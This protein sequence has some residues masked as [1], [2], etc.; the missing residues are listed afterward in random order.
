MVLYSV[1]QSESGRVESPGV[2][3][4]DRSESVH[5]LSEMS[6]TPGA[7]PQSAKMTS[8]KVKMSSHQ[9]SLHLEF[10]ATEQ[11]EYTS[12]CTLPAEDEEKGEQMKEK[13][14]ACISTQ[15]VVLKQRDPLSPDQS[16]PQKRKHYRPEK[17]IEPSVRQAPSASSSSG[18]DMPVLE[19]GKRAL[20]GSA[21]CGTSSTSESDVHILRVELPLLPSTTGQGACIML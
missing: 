15:R 17:T 11:G 1:T 7:R 2:A 3:T 9:A 8:Q 12:A 16:T 20:E 6:A 13:T 19:A 4:V 18:K 21:N 10:T 5:S 14:T